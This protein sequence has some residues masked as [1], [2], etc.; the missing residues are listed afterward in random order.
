MTLEGA[1][2]HLKNNKKNVTGDIDLI[3]NLETVK[4]FLYEIKNSLG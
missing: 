2:E 1:R 3:K 4:A